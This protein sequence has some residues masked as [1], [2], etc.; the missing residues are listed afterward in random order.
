MK[1]KILTLFMVCLVAF[2]GTEAFAAE[3]DVMPCYNVVTAANSIISSTDDGIDMKILVCTPSDT[4]LD[5]VNIEVKLKRTSGAVA[6]I[7]N[8]TMTKQISTFM[9][10][11]TANVSVNAYYF[12]EY[13]AKCYKNGSLVDTVTGTSRTIYHEI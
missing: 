4:S 8:Q 2:A 7:Y 1:K 10:L 5:R 3:Y 13:T 11:E 12:Y 6:K 9:F